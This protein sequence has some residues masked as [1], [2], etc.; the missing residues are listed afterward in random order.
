M[1]EAS[2]TLLVFFATL[3]HFDD[4]ST[5]IVGMDMCSMQHAGVVAE[6]QPAIS[7]RH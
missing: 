2:A 5:Y 6:G 7:D 3:L 1:H 4:E